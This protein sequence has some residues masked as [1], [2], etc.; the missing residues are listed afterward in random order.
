MF[1]VHRAI[2]LS[3]WGNTAKTLGFLRN[4][5]ATL[6]ASG[7]EDVK[8]IWVLSADC[9]V[10]PVESSK[11][12]NTRLTQTYGMLYTITFT[13]HVD[14]HRMDRTIIDGA[15]CIV[16]QAYQWGGHTELTVGAT[17]PGNF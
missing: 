2:H 7:E 8:F 16:E 10:Q 12:F 4:H 13:G 17:E 1:G 9:D 5:P 15:L 3:P 11:V 14:I 6:R